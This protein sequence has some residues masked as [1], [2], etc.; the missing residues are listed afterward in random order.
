MR[1]CEIEP[2]GAI[3]LGERLAS[4]GARRPFYGE[5]IAYERLRIPIVLDGP[6]MNALAA[7]LPDGPERSDSASRMK[8]GLF[9]KF[10]KR[11]FI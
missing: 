11:C 6:H 10:A 2:F 1:R 8:S 3:D 5:R 9:N 7:R 4:A